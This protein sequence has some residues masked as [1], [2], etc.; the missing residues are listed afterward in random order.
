MIVASNQAHDAERAAD[1]DTSSVQY[2]TFMLAGEEYGIEIL[3]VQ[4]IKG[5]EP[6]TP[7]P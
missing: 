1:S 7:I 2:L 4:E 6:A 5:W 3:R